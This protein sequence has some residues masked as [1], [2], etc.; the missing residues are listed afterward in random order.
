MYKEILRS[1]GGIDAYPVVSL[2]IFVT[3]FAILIA[4]VCRMD[5]RRVGRLAAL[6]LDGGA[7]DAGEDAER[8]AARVGEV[9][10]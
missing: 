1:I 8:I 6:P 2:I 3:F 5:A 4:R 7:S 10:R 9:S